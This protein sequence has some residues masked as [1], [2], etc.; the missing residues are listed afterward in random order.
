MA[1]TLVFLLVGAIIAK[2][3]WEDGNRHSRISTRDFGL[4]VLLWFYLL[5]FIS[6]FIS[7]GSVE[8]FAGR[9]CPPQYCATGQTGRQAN[10][11][12]FKYISVLRRHTQKHLAV[13]RMS[14]MLNVKT[15]WLQIIRIL[16]VTILLPLI[17]FRSTRIN[18]KDLTV[19]S[20]SG[21]RGAVGLALGLMVYENRKVQGHEFRILQFFHIGCIV[22]LS[23][24]IQGSTMASLLQV[25]PSLVVS[26]AFRLLD[27]IKKPIII[28]EMDRQIEQHKHHHSVETCNALAQRTK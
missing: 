22:L 13:S 18:R 24:T 3:I 5:V 15:L 21:L 19:L 11:T 25:C 8:T 14:D 23:V 28:L 12:H 6:S 7:Q 16:M 2:E 27:G 17:N 1:N 26:I 4:A 10:Y 20:W 9:S